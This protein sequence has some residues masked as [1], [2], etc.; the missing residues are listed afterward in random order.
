[1]RPWRMTG[2]QPP[3]PGAEG[4]AVNVGSGPPQEAAEWLEYKTTAQ[5]T[6]LAKER[7]AD[8]YPAPHKKED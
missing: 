5:P 6:T 8:R 4:P 3:L 2:G 1:M 7:A